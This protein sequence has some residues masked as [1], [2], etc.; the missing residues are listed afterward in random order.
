MVS[1]Y[2][3]IFA[4]D[5]NSSFDVEFIVT[6][7][8]SSTNSST[9]ASTGFTMLDFN[10]QGNGMGIGKV[11]ETQETLEIGMKTKFFFD[12]EFGA[13]VNAGEKFLQTLIDTIYPVGSIYLA[14]NH[15][16][17]GELF[18]GTW[19]RI[20][21]HFLWATTSGGIIGQ[22][23][24]ESEV[25]LTQNQIPAHQHNINWTDSDGNAGGSTLDNPLIRYAN[26]GTGYSGIV[27]GFTGGGQS[28]NNMP[29]YIQVSVWRRT[30]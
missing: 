30:A 26:S 19:V 2:D 27:T 12:V 29:P 3:Y 17:P 4:A 20:E 23:G 14:Y 13:D 10:A 5:E 28:H 18:G 8:H 7:R 16:N 24:G 6:D 9:S 25:T 15:T 21:N 22:T 1:G 11:S